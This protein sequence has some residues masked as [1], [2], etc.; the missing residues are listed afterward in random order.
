[1][2]SIINFILILV[3]FVIVGIHF[4]YTIETNKLLNNLDLSSLAE[5]RELDPFILQ[6]Y[7]RYVTEGVMR[8]VMKKVNKEITSEQAYREIRANPQ[9]LYKFLDAV[10]AEFEQA[11][12]SVSLQ[13]IVRGFVGSDT[14]TDIDVSIAENKPSANANDEDKIDVGGTDTTVVADVEGFWLY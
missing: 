8:I 10:L 1:M 3:I 4:K 12:K 11:S 2:L 5:F 14:P 6:L 13:D 9:E 7:R